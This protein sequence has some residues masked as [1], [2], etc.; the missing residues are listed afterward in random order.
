MSRIPRLSPALGLA[1]VLAACSSDLPTFAPDAPVDVDARPAFVTSEEALPLSLCKSWIGEG[2]L[3]DRSWTFTISSGGSAVT[4]ALE[5]GECVELGLFPAGAS[6]TVTE[7]VPSGFELGLILLASRTEIDADGFPVSTLI[8]DP[9]SPSVT[10]AVSEI[11]TIWFKNR[12]GELPPPPPP[13]VGGE[14]CTPGFWRQPH[15]YAFWAAPYVPGV[16]T[17]GEVFDA[18]QDAAVPGNGR[19]NAAGRATSGALAS[20]TLLSEAVQLTGGGVNAL[21]RHAVAALLNAA[22][23]DVA[24][25]L[26][27][28]EIIDLVNR[29]LA[30]GDVNGAKDLLEGLNEQGCTVRK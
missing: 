29:A 6:V 24:Y 4:R 5:T 14:G 12:K 21:A 13:V 23:A 8:E 22:S 17:W 25:D 10:V 28:D 11:Q 16:T 30:S 27:V 20:G 1:A 15:H 3:P 2:P 7:E 26:S 18:P 9:A 19:G